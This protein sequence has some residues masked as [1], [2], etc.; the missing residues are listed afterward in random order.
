MNPLLKSAIRELQDERGIRLD[1]LLDL[2]H[3]FRLKELADAVLGIQKDLRSEA[4]IRPAVRVGSVLFRRLSIGAIEFLNKQVLTWWAEDD[5]KVALSYAFCH[6]H[7]DDPALIWGYEG[8]KREWAKMLESWR[9]T[10]GVSWPELIQAVQGFQASISE[11]DALLKE[12]LGPG[13]PD[14]DEKPKKES[15]GPMIDLLS[16]QYSFTVPP[17]LTPA[18][19]WIW[20]VP[21]DEVESM[22]DACL[23]RIEMDEKRKRKPGTFSTDPDKLYIRAH[24]AFRK[25][26]DTIV[27]EKRGKT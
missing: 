23:N 26:L 20:R 14:R 1:P 21:I 2:D 10:I 9:R 4:I 5:D 25:Y 8:R 13:K 12:I 11:L 15:Y 6:A 17:G 27:E 22:V 24:F 19:Y 16:S 7:A 3:I 18:E